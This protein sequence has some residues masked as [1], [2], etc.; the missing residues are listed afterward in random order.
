MQILIISGG[1]GTRMQPLSTPKSSWSFRGTTLLEYTLSDL[2]KFKPSQIVIVVSP[3]AVAEST[4]LAA[5]FNA[6][7][8]VQ[9]DPL[10]MANA[11]S[12][13]G[14]LLDI[15]T[16]TLIVNASTI[17]DPQMYIS[18]AS[19][20]KTS[21]DSLLLAGQK[22]DTYRPGGYFALKDGLVTAII[23]KPG[24]DH[25]PSPFYKHVLDFFPRTDDLIRAMTTTSSVEDDV[26][27]VALTKMI[28]KTPTHLVEI[29]GY[30]SGLKH[31]PDV[32]KVMENILSNRLVPGI[33]SS[34]QIAKS[35]V[36]EGDVEIADNV[37]IFDHATI[38]GPAYIGAGSVIGN[39]ALIR[40]SCVE[41]NCE[42]GYNTEV[43]RSYVGPGSKCHTSYIGDSIIE[44]EANLA[45][46]T[47][48][49]NLRFDG[50]NVIV[51]LPSGKIDTGRRKFGAILARGVKTG[52]HTSIMPGYVAAPGTI[53]QTNQGV[54]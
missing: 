27:E 42:I 51:H 39:G 17:R 22:T 10:G 30:H 37:H 43:A 5:Q 21:P 11:V 20:I 48:T 1:D 23:E 40:A 47:I 3:S 53:L 38:K 31:A 32:L 7:I 15:S 35:A 52:I 24:P 18:M 33:A 13:A 44:G 46:G 26:Y 8:V 54:K 36:I 2:T 19:A 6:K 50:Q 34:A 9:S 4:I 49:A 16:G 25:M 12:V 29:S 28:A 14:P 45:A 41:A